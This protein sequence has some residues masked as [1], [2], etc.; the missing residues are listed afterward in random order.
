[1][2]K[3]SAQCIAVIS[4]L[5]VA[6]CSKTEPEA[7]PEERKATAPPVTADSTLVSAAGEDGGSD[8]IWRWGGIGHALSSGKCRGV[9]H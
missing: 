6:S 7:V 5:F 9:R 1:M 8:Q 3:K 2:I 4:V